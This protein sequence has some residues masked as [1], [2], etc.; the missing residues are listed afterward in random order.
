M[1]TI[2]S[3]SSLVLIDCDVDTD[4]EFFEIAEEL[5]LVQS[6]DILTIQPLTS[7]LKKL[8]MSKVLDESKLR[9]L[10]NKEVRV[11]ELNDRILISALSVYNSPDTTYQ[12]D[13]FNRDTIQYLTIPFEERNYCKYL[14]ELAKCK[15]RVSGYSKSLLS[16]F[17]K[18]SKMIYPI[19]KKRKK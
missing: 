6:L 14:G 12:M 1:N 17:N 13:L 15:L 10:I 19:G 8:K 4:P 7:L 9:I 3:N 2:L 16:S 11:A 5:Y 18:L